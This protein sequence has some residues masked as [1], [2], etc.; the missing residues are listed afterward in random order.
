MI[1]MNAIPALTHE[2]W[3]GFCD[4]KAMLL[5]SLLIVGT[6]LFWLCALPIAAL[7]MMVVK[8]WDTS[9]ALASGR[10]VRPNPLILRRRSISNVFTRRRAARVA[11]I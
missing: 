10:M 7:A 2:S 3:P 6:V 11:Q 1:T 4:P 5:E 9:V 8:I